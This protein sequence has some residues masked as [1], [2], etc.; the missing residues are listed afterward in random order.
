MR[1][2]NTSAFGALFALSA[3]VGPI[4]GQNMGRSRH[5]RLQS[6]MRDSLKVVVGYVLV[7]WLALAFSSSWIANAFQAEGES[8]GMI[9][10]FC[11]LWPAAL[12]LTAR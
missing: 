8:R 3:L 7:M 1:T 12:S 9:V 5:D 4:L 11:T 6:T 10:F 2:G